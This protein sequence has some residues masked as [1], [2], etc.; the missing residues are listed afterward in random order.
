MAVV[1]TIIVHGTYGY[2]G[3]P[4]DVAAWWYPGSEFW[5]AGE[6]RGVQ[7]A[8]RGDPFEWAANVAGL[9]LPRW[10]RRLISRNPSRRFTLWK[11]EAQALRWY[12]AAHGL[13]EVNLLCHSHGAQVGVYLAYRRV[14]IPRV[15]TLLTVAMPRRHDMAP[16]YTGAAT[17]VER[18]VALEGG[19]DR[20]WG[21]WGRIGDEAWGAAPL[22]A[23][24]TRITE[25]GATHTSVLDPAL[26]TLRRW[27]RWLTD[28]A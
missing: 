13:K 28:A 27:W 12:C 26:W 15:H 10:L 20:T 24:V 23:R 2:T 17:R 18:W 4:R 16:I 3:T 11:A 9:G 5:L 19:A 6:A 25:P 7:F 21:I 1:P 22:P 8:G 14:A